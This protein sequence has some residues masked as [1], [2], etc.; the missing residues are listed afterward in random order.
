[1]SG[2]L[3]FSGK[4]EQF[5]RAA[6]WIEQLAAEVG[7]SDQTDIRVVP[8]NHDIDRE[9]IDYFCNAVHERLRSSPPQRLEQELRYMAMATWESNPLLPKLQEYR[10]YA[11]RYDCDFRPVERLSWRK[12]YAFDDNHRF[13][14]LGLTSVLVCDGNDA[15]DQMILGSNQYIFDREDDVEFVVMVHHPLSWF[16]DQQDAQRYL[17]RA[18]VILTGHE[19]LL[20]VS[21]ESTDAGDEFLHVCAGATN[22][23]ETAGPYPYRYNWLDFSLRIEGG[24][25]YRETPA[26]VYGCTPGQFERS[27]LRPTVLRELAP[28]PRGVN[29]IA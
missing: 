18:R 22:P 16:M 20:R 5:H 21:K 28:S 29:L 10:V 12:P 4:K 23:P 3:A 1:V 15:K 8:G 27:A 24:Q 19:H 17:D 11:S 6:G 14:I 9:R 25:Q 13:E 26:V 2:D 7:C